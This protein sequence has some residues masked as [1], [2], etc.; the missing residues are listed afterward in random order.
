[1]E[2]LRI[3]KHYMGTTRRAIIWI[4]LGL[5][6]YKLQGQGSYFAHEFTQGRPSELYFSVHINTAI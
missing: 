5:A 2:M 4:Y 6:A 1:M 3:K